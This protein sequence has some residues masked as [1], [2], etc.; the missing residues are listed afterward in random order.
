[1]SGASPKPLEEEDDW[2]TAEIVL[3]SQSKTKPT[4]KP[5]SFA[6]TSASA[7]PPSLRP[8][9][10]EF[11]PRP[12]A[13]PSPS[14]VPQPAQGQAGPSR[15]LINGGAGGPSGPRILSRST[16]SG[17]QRYD[18]QGTAGE[19]GPP[20]GVDGEDDWFR[21]SRPMSNRQIWD[22]ANTRA[23]PTTIIS[24]QP[25]PLPPTPGIKLLRRPTPSGGGDSRFPQGSGAGGNRT[26][27]LE[28]REEE[29]KA[30]RERIF[31]STSASVGGGIGDLSLAESGR[32]GSGE[33]SSRKAGNGEGSSKR[34][35]GNG[36]GE[37]SR[38]ASPAGG[39]GQKINNAGGS[40][41][42]RY[43]GRGEGDSGSNTPF[44]GLVPSQIRGE[45]KSPLPSPAAAAGGPRGGGG[46][47][48][49][50]QPLGPGEGGGFGAQDVHNH[51][52]DVLGPGGVLSPG[53]PASGGGGFR[54]R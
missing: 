24:P 43:A 26:K 45:R 19:V 17:T 7:L 29:Y 11:Q 14:T 41:G 38:R 9:A 47:G 27:T 30:A 34:G 33:G 52:G 13:A 21:G 49:V 31:G 25:L 40:G 10:N 2:E 35:G 54:S 12:R 28:E 48:V 6:S 20:S 15:I 18:G 1:M 8:Q 23:T 36:S 32:S 3:P 5:Q 37:G 44:E 4:P 51:Y 39:R 53:R 50:R 16:P 42:G 46:G 22:S